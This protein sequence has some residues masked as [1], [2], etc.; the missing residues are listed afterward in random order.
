MKKI[1]WMTWKDLSHP[2]AGGA[3]RVNE[4]IALRLARDGN[5]V[6][7]LVSGFKGSKKIEKK[8]GYT[9]IRVGGRFS[10]YFCAYL[11]YKNSLKGWADLVIDEM[12]TIPFFCRFY[13]AEPNCILSYQLCREIWFYQMKF[14]VS[15][16]GYLLEP[17]YLFLL[18]GSKVL[19]ESASARDDLKRFGFKQK[20]IRVFPIGIQSKP[21]DNLEFL[22]KY[23]SPTLLSIGGIRPMKQTLDQVKAFEIAKKNIPK[24]KLKIA[25]NSDGAYGERVISYIKESQYSSDIEYYGPI[26]DQKKLELMRMSHFIMV[27]SVKEGW[28]LIVTESNSQGT[29]AIVYRADGLR[30][31]VRENE[32]GLIC[33]S[34]NPQGLAQKVI[35]GFRNDFQYKHMALKAWFWSGEL[36]LENSY[37]SFLKGI[38]ELCPN[39]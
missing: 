12:N 29:P 34:N 20:N 14:P 23:E 17:C 22:Y 30:D 15:L 24:L 3:E 36:T 33:D 38:D 16:I 26:N 9:I 2:E 27:T 37:Q 21:L 35:E 6:I 5:Q 1:L 19:T 18:S 10:V 13:V 31:S 28:G 11:Y 4:E 32:T 7:L 8:N 25:G 39:R